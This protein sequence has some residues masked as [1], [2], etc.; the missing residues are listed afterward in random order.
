MANYDK[1]E[2]IERSIPQS[3]RIDVVTLAKLDSWWNEQGQYIRSMSQLIS[4]SLDLL[5]E[6]IEKDLA[7]DNSRLN[8]VANAYDYL[9]AKGLL[10]QGKIGQAIGMDNLRKEGI[11]PRFENSAVYNRMHNKHSIEA[12]GGNRELGPQVE[13]RVNETEIDEDLKLSE[14]INS[15][16]IIFEDNKYTWKDGRPYKY[17]ELTTEDNN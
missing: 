1:E 13:N 7:V 3:S 5:I 2:K 17:G 12:Y 16:E 6:V 10:Q 4:W 14:A 15:G 8:T 11:N 9:T